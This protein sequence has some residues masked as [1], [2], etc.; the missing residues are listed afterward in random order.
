MKG[1]LNLFVYC[2][3]Q[4]ISHKSAFLTTVKYGCICRGQI[5][6]DSSFSLQLQTTFYV[7]FTRVFKRTKSD[8]FWLNLELLDCSFHFQFTT[9]IS[10]CFFIHLRLTSRSVSR[11]YR[12]RNLSSHYLRLSKYSIIYSRI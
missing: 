1:D 8:A 5:T 7:L 2:K 11:N 6:L 4:A 9:L 10:L 3:Y 12:T